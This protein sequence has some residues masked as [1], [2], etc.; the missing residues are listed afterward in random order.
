MQDAMELEAAL[1]PVIGRETSYKGGA[2][3]PYFG[4]IALSPSRSMAQAGR[5]AR[6]RVAYSLQGLGLKRVRV[7]PA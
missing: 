6:V 4:G 5:R 7:E 3:R 2:S 1:L